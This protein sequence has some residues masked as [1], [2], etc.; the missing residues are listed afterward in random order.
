MGMPTYFEWQSSAIDV[1]AIVR[2]L[3]TRALDCILTEDFGVCVRIS[4]GDVGFV[5]Q[6]GTFLNHAELRSS[7]G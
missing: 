2:A 3:P 5:L 4:Q 6:S 7:I 1:P